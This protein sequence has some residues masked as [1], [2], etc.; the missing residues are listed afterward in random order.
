MQ[1]PVDTIDIDIKRVNK[2]PTQ[3]STTKAH[4]IIHGIGRANGVRRWAGDK[5]DHKDC[6]DKQVKR[7][8]SP[9]DEGKSAAW[10]RNEV[11]KVIRL[12]IVAGGT[13]VFESV[14][15]RVM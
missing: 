8:V 9:E 1:F 10:W 14:I 3:H 12:A 15:G 7:G 5:F 11:L 13:L 4:N 6:K 2:S